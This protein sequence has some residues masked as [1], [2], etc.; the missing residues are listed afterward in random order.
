MEST[1]N[2]E[3]ARVTSPS[4]TTPA[5]AVLPPN[6][7]PH[8]QTEGT[9]HGIVMPPTSQYNDTSWAAGSVVT[10]LQNLP[11]SG[12]PAV[13]HKTSDFARPAPINSPND[14]FRNMT[15]QNIEGGNHTFR[16]SKTQGRNNDRA[17]RRKC[18][19]ESGST[20]QNQKAAQASQQIPWDQTYRPQM[21][22]FNGVLSDASL[23]SG[24][25][26]T[27]MPSSYKYLQMLIK[28]QVSR[29]SW[30]I[31]ILIGS[32][33]IFK[34]NYR[35]RNPPISS[36]VNRDLHSTE[37]DSISTI[38]AQY[39]SGRPILSPCIDFEFAVC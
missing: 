3:Q 2:S 19:A 34:R 16:P 20:G 1:Q 30:E 18:N 33:S 9:Y 12:S 27:G 32:R 14:P 10:N 37:R 5:S 26:T 28:S 36:V 4:S 31:S 21:L 38:S 11:T 8:A 15:I 6:P 39:Y 24:P 25:Y 22:G 29:I 13:N 23:P 35:R 17:K 7:P